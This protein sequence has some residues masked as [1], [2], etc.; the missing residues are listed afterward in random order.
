M[1]QFLKESYVIGI[2]ATLATDT[3]GRIFLLTVI[4]YLIGQLVYSSYLSWFMGGFGSIPFGPAGFNIIDVLSLFPLALITLTESLRKS[5]WPLLKKSLMAILRFLLPWVFGIAATALLR[6]QGYQ[7]DPESNLWSQVSY[8]GWIV[9]WVAY[10]AAIA[11]DFKCKVCKSLICSLLLLL[12]SAA[13]FFMTMTALPVTEETDVLGNLRVPLLVTRILNEFTVLGFIFVILPLGLSWIGLVMAERAVLD[14]TL[15][16]VL[17]LS[18]KQ[19]MPGL[20]TL[21]SEST[22]PQAP[23]RRRFRWFTQATLPDEIKPDVYTYLPEQELYLIVTL[24]RNTLFYFPNEDSEG[25]GRTISISN[26][27]IHGIEI[28]GAR[29]TSNKNKEP[30]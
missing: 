29:Y 23:K 11:Q 27:L 13:I 8:L 18:L 2:I 4:A 28:E 20:G 22:V 24:K 17:K 7:I 16:K 10:R 9:F 15:S 5:W 6:A 19:P 30:R 25:H 21:Q 14:G 12:Q 1:L 3:T 26:G